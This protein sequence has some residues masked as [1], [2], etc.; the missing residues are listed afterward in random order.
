MASG[1]SS[2]TR[3]ER[4][5]E[6]LCMLT[7]TS[8]Y[9]KETEAL[10]LYWSA[11][12]AERTVVGCVTRNLKRELPVQSRALAQEICQHVTNFLSAIALQPF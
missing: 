5:I 8:R 10:G 7:E 9:P 3:E 12:P 4:A 2:L 1:A 11:G 6:T